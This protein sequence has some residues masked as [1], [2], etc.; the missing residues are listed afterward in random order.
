MNLRDLSLN[1]DDYDDNKKRQT[2]S[3]ARLM[4]MLEAQGRHL[5]ADGLD[6]HQ[7]IVNDEKM[8][9]SEKKDLLQKVL[10]RA[11]SNGDVERVDS[12]LGGEAKD[13]LD[14]NAVD[15]DGT[16]ALIYA[17]CFVS[18]SSCS[19]WIEGKVANAD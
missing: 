8:P 18:L 17:S 5:A 15:D 13:L 6:D 12:L 1:D 2:D 10:H 7:A 16:P 19:G 11:A 4:E 9:E 3:E 14:L